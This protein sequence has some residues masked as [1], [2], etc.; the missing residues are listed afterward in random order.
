MSRVD[1][2]PLDAA[3]EVVE[4]PLEVN[5]STAQG[6]ERRAFCDNPRSCPLE[7]R[8]ADA[9]VLQRL[10]SQTS[11]LKWFTPGPSHQRL[12][13]SCSWSFP[14][15][16]H[17][18][19][20]V[21]SLTSM[22]AG[23]AQPW[24]VDHQRHGRA[25]TSCLYGSLRRRL[26]VAAPCRLR[27]LG[28]SACEVFSKGRPKWVLGSPCALR[29]WLQGAMSS[30]FEDSS[31]SVAQPSSRGASIAPEPVDELL[32]PRLGTCLARVMRKRMP[33]W[34]QRQRMTTPRTWLER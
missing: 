3:R 25:S 29:R 11:Q 2:R 16:H 4:I 34:P 27:V 6:S 15:M 28:P 24:P 12:R 26:G 31:G 18:Q 13:L 9:Q 14:L 21:H 5:T 33:R 32:W 20:R 8:R 1:A 17:G 30:S 22:A 19:A 7:P 10:G 23:A